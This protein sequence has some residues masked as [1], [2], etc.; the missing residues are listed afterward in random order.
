MRRIDGAEPTRSCPRDAAAEVFV[1]DLAVQ[2][3]SHASCGREIGG[4]QG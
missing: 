2:H 1:L 3:H 4:R